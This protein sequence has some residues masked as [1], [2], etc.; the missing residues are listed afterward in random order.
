MTKHAVILSDEAKQQL[1]T[2]R[3]NIDLAAPQWN[4]TN[5]PLIALKK[6]NR[7][8]SGEE[9]DASKALE[10]VVYVRNAVSGKGEAPSNGALTFAVREAR[11]HGKSFNILTAELENQAKL[12]EVS[13]GQ[14]A[15]NAR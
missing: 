1:A 13:A 12:L 10:D 7:L 11:D 9:F 5:T 3:D 15:R 4:G 6:V 8:L 2:I 14:A